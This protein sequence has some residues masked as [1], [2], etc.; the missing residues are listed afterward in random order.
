MAENYWIMEIGN[1]SRL[2]TLILGE[3]IPFYMCFC[4]KLRS[5]RFNFIRQ[6]NSLLRALGD[7]FLDG[8][9]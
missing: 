7:P 1:P 8:C 2:G 6:M 5:F 4:Y 3:I 9:I